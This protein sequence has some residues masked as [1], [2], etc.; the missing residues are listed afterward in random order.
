M[1]V[2]TSLANGIIR[3]LDSGTSIVYATGELVAFAGAEA[4][5]V[6]VLPVELDLHVVGDIIVEAEGV[7]HT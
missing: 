2:Y 6:V 3:V 4:V 1:V 5:V 7:C